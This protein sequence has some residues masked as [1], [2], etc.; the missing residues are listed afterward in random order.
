MTQTKPEEAEWT[1]EKLPGGHHELKV[2]ARCKDVSGVSAAAWPGT[3]LPAGGGPLLYRICVGINDY[4]DK[5]LKLGSARQDAEAVFA[6]LEKYCTGNGNCF[7]AAA[8]VKLLDKDATRQAVLDA[9]QGVR[10]ARVKPGDLVVVFFGGHGVVQQGEFYL[11]TREADP[12]K[13]LKDKSLSG[14]D[15]QDAFQDMPCSVLLLMDACHSAAGA[16]AL[17][18]ATDDLT[19]ALS[20]DQVAVTV[21][22]AAM[23]YET[24]GE[25]PG[26]GLFTDAL[27]KGLEAGAGVPYDPHDKQMYVHHLYSHVF[28]EV[29]RA[30]AGRQNPFLNMP[31]TVP[32][33]AIRQVPAK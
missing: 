13:P 23:G 21:L 18:P 28:S 22:A 14:K 26:H 17:K 25:R 24:A 16:A 8:G 6:G 27:L 9:F 19:R 5:D 4:D 30:S 3:G 10:K 11:L 7:G 12:G 1:V 32:P 29:R 2:L 31:W 33:L 15:L 20:D